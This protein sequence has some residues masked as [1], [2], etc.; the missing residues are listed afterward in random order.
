MSDPLSQQVLRYAADFARLHA[1]AEEDRERLRL[2]E[3]QLLRV[4]RVSLE[5]VRSLSLEDAAR[6]ILD[7]FCELLRLSGG[8]LY[9]FREDRFRLTARRSAAWD[10]FP[11][12]AAVSVSDVSALGGVARE[13][14]SAPWKRLCG[15]P[16]VVVPIVG[17]KRPVGFVVAP[18]R[19]AEPDGADDAPGVAA[20]ELLTRLLTGQ[21]GAVLENHLL[22]ERR[23]TAPL[24]RPRASSSPPAADP[25][26][27]GRLLGDSPAMQEC[28][29][30]L[31]RLAKVDSIV[32]LTGETGTGKSL[33]ARYL[34]ERSPR[35]ARP[36]VAFNCAAL[37]EALI[38]SELFGHE[39]GA[40]TGASKLRRGK[41]EQAK[42]GTLFM[43]EVG[44][45]PL[46]LQSKLLTFLEDR[47]FTR[48][49]G[50]AEIEADVR[51][52]SA[53]NTDLDA[54]V[55]DGR[56]RAD[57]LFR[58][59]VFSVAFPPLRE[60]GDDV[61]ALART[62]AEEVARRYDLSVPAITPEID[63][64]LMAYPWPGNVREL[65]NVMEKAIILTD[66][67]AISADLLPGGVEA[68]GA[69]LTSPESPD[70]GEDE[71]ADVPFGEAKARMIAQ[72]ERG[73]LGNLLRTT[74]GN[75]AAAA[76]LAQVDKKNLRA[77]IKK[78]GIELEALRQAR[79]ID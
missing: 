54:A 24:R 53:T 1:R 14:D 6:R 25:D 50:E 40:F 8:A 9:A 75:V 20:L 65:R 55:Q 13:V 64:R 67:P 32:L 5:L 31:D 48:L 3:Q 46:A 19:L 66:G 41:I 77:K 27:T 37:P 10:A 30:L 23:V 7:A 21:A 28:I 11:G 72:W 22:E 17:R 59:N 60:R 78:H 12:V 34:H 45:L 51:I 70:R 56:F 71:A 39:A 18:G 69:P 73:Y 15:P 29:R 44:E 38:E 62:L 43:D 61:L 63:A 2:L 76:R 74:G 42:G 26:A 36:F 57:L 68:S 79:R 52:V 16:T 47:R 49:G 35:V 58:L 33:A 4:N